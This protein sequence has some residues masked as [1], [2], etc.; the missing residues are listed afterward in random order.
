MSPNRLVLIYYAFI[1]GLWGASRIRGCFRRW[2]QP[3]LR[4]PEWF[5]NVQVQ[6][7]F[8][9]GAGAKLLRAYRLRMLSTLAIDI[10][11]ATAIFISGRNVLF[12]SWF[13][14]AMTAFIH[15]FHMF[16]VDLAERQARTYAVPEAEQPVAAVAISLKTRRLR[17]YSNRNLEIAMAVSSI[18]AITWLVRYYLATPE[19]HDLRLVFGLPAL[20][21]YTQTGFLFAKQVVVAWR[22][23]VPEILAEEYLEAREATRQFYLNVCDLARAMNSVAL[24]LWPVMLSV[25]PASRMRVVLLW[26]AGWMAVSVAAGV[27][28][29]MK[30]KRL[31]TVTLRARPMRLPEFMGSTAP[32]WL[33]CYQPSAPMLVLKGAR[34]YSLNLANRLAFQ[35]AAYLGGWAALLVLF[36]M[37]H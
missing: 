20:V 15:V 36:R 19:H 37:G 6:P 34:G 17:D 11:G 9:D 23:P 30:R 26:L 25:S 31:L 21:L 14:L 10:A 24:L 18:A 2:Q 32:S 1:C 27:W 3:L 35:G 7:G 29:E 5:F 16:S 4:G 8:Y 33:L 28:Q 13:L 12:L 22:T